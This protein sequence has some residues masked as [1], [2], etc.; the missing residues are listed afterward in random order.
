MDNRAFVEKS[1]QRLLAKDKI[2]CKHKSSIQL[3]VSTLRENPLTVQ[4]DTPN[5][6]TFQRVT[7]VAQDENLSFLVISD[8]SSSTTGKCEPV[9]ADVLPYADDLAVYRQWSDFNGA[10]RMPVEKSTWNDQ[11]D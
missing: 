7:G 5:L 4:N 3:I 1:Q 2:S 8:I 9:I 10:W 11:N 6:D